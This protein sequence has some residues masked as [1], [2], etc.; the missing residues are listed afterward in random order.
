ME[1]ELFQTVVIDGVIH[2][3]KYVPE[4]PKDEAVTADADTGTSPE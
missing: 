2:H 3:I 4:E 1:N